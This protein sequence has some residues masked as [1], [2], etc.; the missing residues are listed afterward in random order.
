MAVE[1]TRAR[2]DAA[3][4]QFGIFDWIDRNRLPLSD[5]YEQRLQCLEYADE[6]GFY[7]Y[8]LAEH[9]ATPLGMAP[10]P[11]VF[12]S[13]ASQRTQRIR[14]G[15]L[16]YLL[17]LYN[18]LRLLQEICMLD[19]LSRGRLEVGIGR[20][21]SPY[22]LAFF[23]T[24]PPQA[25]GMFREALDI[26][27]AGFTNG[28]VSY[29]GEYYSLK[30]VRLHLEPFQ[31]P[32]PPLWYP[33]DNT[34]SIT[35]L[36]QE[37]LN[38]ITHYPPMATMRRLFDLYKQVWQEHRTNPKRL[39]AHVVDPKYG[40]VR[41]VYVAETD[42]QALQDARAAFADFI[43]NFN[44]LRVVNNDTSGRAAYLADF[45]AR[46]A[47]GLHVVGSPDTVKTQVQEHIRITGSNY[48]VGSFFFG[49]LTTEQMLRSLRLFAE[50]VMPTLHR[51]A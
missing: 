49:T 40:I 19:N 6:A 17:P 3:P 28:E 25:R 1:H 20:G 37:G 9:Q 10:S 18:P 22:E 23:N 35:W 30:S 8:H 43:Y 16:V 45:D 11:S 27:T 12:L 41:H 7:C 39:N 13:A 42:A 47:E 21:V 36:A 33:T 4:M 2:A 31:R 29:S 32:Y 24:T 46:L 34:N 14:L 15:P 5:L 48:F 51:I 26:L 44:Y 50:E 38:T